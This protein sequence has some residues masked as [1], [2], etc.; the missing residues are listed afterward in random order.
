MREEC[1]WSPETEMV[2]A[3]YRDRDMWNGAAGNRVE[4]R[5]SVNKWIDD[6]GWGA[7]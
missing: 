2:Q 4:S 1:E 7:E 3:D 5:A 6:D